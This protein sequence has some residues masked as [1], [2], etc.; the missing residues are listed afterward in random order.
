MDAL[1]KVKEKE[2]CIARCMTRR[3]S[4]SDRD[5]VYCI[6]LLLGTSGKPE[7]TRSLLRGELAAT[8]AAQIQARPL[9]V[10]WGARMPE[11]CTTTAETKERATS[12]PDRMS[13]GYICEADC[14]VLGLPSQGA[15][16]CRNAPACIFLG[17]GICRLERPT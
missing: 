17:A 7:A 1:S 13:P 11:R 9:E 8:R 15:Y 10:D 6:L 14:S 4:K 3:R 12:R 5:S 2:L 16:A